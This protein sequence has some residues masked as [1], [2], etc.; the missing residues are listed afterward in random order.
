M[1][2]YGRNLKGWFLPGQVKCPEIVGVWL[3]KGH[4]AQQFSDVIACELLGITIEKGGGIPVW[5][6]EETLLG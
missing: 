4:A 6:C 2:Q 1:N 5:V 3:K